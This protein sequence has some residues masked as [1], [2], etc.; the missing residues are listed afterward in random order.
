MIH[1]ALLRYKV[2]SAIA[3]L[4]LEDLV[5]LTIILV[6]TSKSQLYLRCSFLSKVPVLWKISGALT[7]HCL[8]CL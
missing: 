4:R 8:S 5:T 7:S 2:A 6:E 3:V 1:L